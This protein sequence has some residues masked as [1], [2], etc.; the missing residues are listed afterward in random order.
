[1]PI[2]PAIEVPV[3]QSVSQP[4]P[5]L[6]GDH[7]VLFADCIIC[8]GKC[9]VLFADIGCRFADISDDKLRTLVG[10]SERLPSIHPAQ[11]G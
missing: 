3:S 1:M 8:R 7:F 2:Q 4:F 5:P 6:L 10:E 11:V 9:S